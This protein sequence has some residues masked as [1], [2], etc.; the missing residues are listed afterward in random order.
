MARLAPHQTHLWIVPPYGNRPEGH[1]AALL[2]IASRLP[3]SRDK[4][5]PD[6]Q[7]VGENFSDFASWRGSGRLIHEGEAQ[8]NM[9]GDL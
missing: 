3:V 1:S 2:S 7:R 4:C 5:R 8:G 6:G 9:T